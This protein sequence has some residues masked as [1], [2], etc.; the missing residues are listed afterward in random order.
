MPSLP[1]PHFD[2][3]PLSTTLSTWRTK[4]SV[5]YQ[6]RTGLK[7]FKTCVHSFHQE[8]IIRQP[9]FINI[10][11]IV[12]NSEDKNPKDIAGNVND[13]FPTIVYSPASFAFLVGSQ[14]NT[15]QLMDVALALHFWLHLYALR[16]WVDINHG[17]ETHND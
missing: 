1:A 4:A 9:K 12:E 5:S 17:L 15:I 8:V 13:I 14:S 11:R 7:A 16:V 10:I 3:V 6:L 2:I